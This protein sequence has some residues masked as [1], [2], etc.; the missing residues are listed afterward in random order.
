MKRRRAFDATISFYNASHQT[1]LNET[2]NRET[3]R[4]KATNYIVNRMRR[5][6]EGIKGE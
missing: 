4:R 2:Q 6:N 3:E 1:L 5:T